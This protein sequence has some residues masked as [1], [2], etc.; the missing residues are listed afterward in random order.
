M[1]MA[2]RDLDKRPLGATGLLV[3]L[4]CAGGAIL[5]GADRALGY[6]VPEERALATIRAVFDSPINFL[7]TAAIYGDGASER[8]IG[9][10]IRERGGLPPGFV[11]A[12]KIDR[13]R[14]SGDFSGA[15]AR[16]CVER[17]LEHLG[18]DRLDLVHIHEPERAT[19]EALTGPGGALDVLL[20]YQRRGVIGHLGVAG[21]P[22]DLLIRY[23][24]T[25]HFAVAL[26]HNRHTLLDRAAAPL[27]DIAATRGVAVV[28]GAPYGSGI[29]A[30]GAASGA[31]Y[32]YRE[33][34]PEVIARVRAIE[35]I[36][37]R[38]GV[39]LGA[40][41]LG[42]SLR[43]PRIASTIVGISR[44]ERV[45]ETLAWASWPI[46]AAC[47]AELDALDAPRR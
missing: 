12:T 44:P 4:L 9:R 47:W 3:G 30:K 45:A 8:L 6:A 36:C 26:T 10:V 21:T 1:T 33:P 22:I 31:R 14:E 32:G 29:L 23:V 2:M 11:L 24:E 42:F 46:P 41:A 19:F 7:D 5:A 39:P 25:G 20:D 38:Y 40:A 18:L 34:T 35:A 37:G 16:R 27:L 17:S 43:E 15:Q 28:N 13:D